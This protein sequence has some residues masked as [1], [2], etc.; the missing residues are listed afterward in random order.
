M[1]CNRGV[2]RIAKK[3][4][5]EFADGKREKIES[6]SYGT[7][8][9]MKSFE[10]NGGYQPAALQTRDG[11]LWYPTPR[12]ATMID[13]KIIVRNLIPPPVHLENLIVDSSSAAMTGDLKLPAGTQRLEFDFAGL[14]FIAPKK[15]NYRYRLEGYDKDWIEA[16]NQHRAFYTSLPYGEYTFRVIADNNDG[17]W[18][19]TGDSYSF[20]IKPFFYQTWWFIVFCLAA[21][22][23][24][25]AAIHFWRLGNLQL[26]HTAVLE[27]RTRI[28]RELHDTLLQGFVGVS[29]Q[30][31]VVASQFQTTPEI[32]ERHL[33]VARKMV[34]HSVTEARRAVQNLRHET[35]DK[36]FAASLEEML[37]RV[38]EGKSIET[39]FK[40]SGGE[41]PFDFASDDAYQIL[42]IAEEAVVNAIKHSHARKISIVCRN[43]APEFKLEI[44]DDGAGFD[45]N[46]A[47]ST[48]NG[49][50]GLLGMKERAEKVGG[51]LYVEPIGT[52]GTKVI[53]ESR[54]NASAKK[55]AARKVSAALKKKQEI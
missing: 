8:D 7:A 12:G 35:D 9:G 34:R 23:A 24:L 52:G 3:D 17:V 27:E 13:P 19:E 4:F 10:C 6:I 50:F 15:V 1:S 16:G 30:L 44:A 37:H 38:T 53:F 21:A 11:R 48:L 51:A 41:K 54:R 28:A 36:S 45:T 39:E 31:S 26:R 20:Q 40:I 18:N 46:N 29:S 49:H 43:E 47:F 14:S 55:R 2:F 25:V 5:N 32:A 42:C 22:T 33:D